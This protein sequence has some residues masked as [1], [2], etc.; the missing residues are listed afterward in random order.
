MLTAAD[1]CGTETMPRVLFYFTSY[2]DNN[3]REGGGLPRAGGKRKEKNTKTQKSKNVPGTEVV[4]L[5]SR[6]YIPTP[7]HIH[8][9]TYGIHTFHTYISYIHNILRIYDIYIEKKTKIW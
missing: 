8:T 7:T 6:K 9:H 1:W 4:I 5:Y 2:I 3:E